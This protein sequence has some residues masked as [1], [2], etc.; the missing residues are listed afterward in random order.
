MDIVKTHKKGKHM[1]TLEKHH[2][3][4]LYRNN[5]HMN[6][7]A[8]QPNNPILRTLHE[9][10][11]RWQHQTDNKEKESRQTHALINEKKNGTGKTSKKHIYIYSYR[12]VTDIMAREKCGLLAGPCSVAI[13]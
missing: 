3:H 13:S 5:L 9:L 2:I 11:N 7:S 1:N 12:T 10:N 8:I 6:D 4:K